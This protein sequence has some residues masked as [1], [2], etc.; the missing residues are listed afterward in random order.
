MDADRVDVFHRRDDDR[1]VGIPDDLKLDLPQAEEARFDERLVDRARLK[2]RP[3]TSRSA[4]GSPALPPPVRR[5][6]PPRGPPG[7]RGGGGGGGA[8]TTI[9]SPVWTPTGSTFSIA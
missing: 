6:P 4:S 5:R 8:P 9:E 1:I 7:P 2:R 3:T